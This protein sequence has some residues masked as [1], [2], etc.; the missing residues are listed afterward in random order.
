MNP[1][2]SITVEGVDGVGK[3]TA[4]AALRR[5]LWWAGHVVSLCPYPGARLRRD[6]AL[7]KAGGLDHTWQELALRH[8][9]EMLAHRPGED[10]HQVNGGIVL[11]D[12]YSLSTLVYQGE[13]DD[14]RGQW[15]SSLVSAVNPST[16]T[17]VL[18]APDEVREARIL[19][20]EGHG[21]DTGKAERLGMLALEYRFLVDSGRYPGA[22]LVDASGT[23]EE[24]LERCW[25]HVEP[26]LGGG[27]AQ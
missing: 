14:S 23:R 26:L 4:I 6:L 19:A 27:A 22:V 5:R 8:V 24:T 16:I 25:A 1:G 13:V 11:R 17:L 2:I 7:E 15:L 12:R 18:D 10:Q 20:R 3:S 21:G 9:A